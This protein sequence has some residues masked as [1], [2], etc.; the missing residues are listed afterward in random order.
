MP[1]RCQTLARRGTG[2]YSRL[3]G[4]ESVV[5]PASHEAGGAAGGLVGV[6]QDK[7]GLR[8]MVIPQPI[9]APETVAEIASREHRP[10]SDDPDGAVIA[11]CEQHIV[12]PAAVVVNSQR[13]PV[14][15]CD[16]NKRGDVVD[17]GDGVQSLGQQAEPLP[18][19]GT[20]PQEFG[21]IAVP[22]GLANT[23]LCRVPA[24]LWTRAELA[25]PVLK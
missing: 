4:D 2:E 8:G 21:L 16:G 12:G 18:R 5:V 9:H 24:E 20:K 17:D 25:Q 15:I 3:S 10:L 7:R 1:P 13:S 23:L 19:H 22:D 14:L 6:R 11:H